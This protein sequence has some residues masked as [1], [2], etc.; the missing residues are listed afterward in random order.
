VT[1]DPGHPIDFQTILE[2]SSAAPG[3]PRVDDFGVPIA[4]AARI[5]AVLLDQDVY[6]GT[7]MKAAALLDML[8]RH[9]WL[10]HHQA[11]AAWTAAEALLAVNGLAIRRDVKASEIAGI[12]RQVAG[13]GVALA[14][15]ART[16]Q[17]WTERLAM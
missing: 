3:A 8:L 15:L 6:F 16:L 4:A 11:R 17:G 5:S 10:E 9:P 12:L 2:I 13:P 7:T 1:Q 14:K